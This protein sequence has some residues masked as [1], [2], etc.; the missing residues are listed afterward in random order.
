MATWRILNRQRGVVTRPI[1]RGR[2]CREIEDTRVFLKIKF[3]DYDLRK[4]FECC[5]KFQTDGNLLSKL[6][7]YIYS[8]IYY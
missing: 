2:T 4:C 7:I 1:S 5:I 3:Y 6:C 8:V